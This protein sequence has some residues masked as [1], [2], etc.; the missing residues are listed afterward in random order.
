MGRTVDNILTGSSVRPLEAHRE[1]VEEGPSRK[2]LRRHKKSLNRPINGREKNERDHEFF[3]RVKVSLHSER[4]KII[5]T[6]RTGRR[7]NGYRAHTLEIYKTACENPL[8]SPFP[9][10]CEA[11]E[12]FRELRSAPSNAALLSVRGSAVRLFIRRE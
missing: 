10:S 7:G 9:R 12:F 6:P 3:A 4:A 2:K 8:F 5:M 11:F 1:P